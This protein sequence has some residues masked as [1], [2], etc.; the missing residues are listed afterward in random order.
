MANPNALLAGK[1]VGTDWEVALIE[2][3]DFSRAF[4]VPTLDHVLFD[5]FATAMTA[6][7]AAPEGTKFNVT[8]TVTPV[9]DA[10]Q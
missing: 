1:K 5:S 7:Q 3:N 6:L 8:L 10:V 4:V 2:E 9:K